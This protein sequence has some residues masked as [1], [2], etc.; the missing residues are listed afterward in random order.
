MA[1]EVNPRRSGSAEATAALSRQ[2]RYQQVVE[3]LRLKEV[4]ISEHERFVVCSNPAA[5][6][7]DAATRDRLVARLEA[8]ISDSDRLSPTKRA[9]LRGVISI[10]QVP[11]AHLLCWLAPLLARIVETRA[12]TTWTRARTQLQRLH[13]GT[14]TGSAGIF[15]QTT[16][17]DTETRR[18]HQ[19]PRR[20]APTPDPAP[21]HRDV[22][23]ALTRH[24]THA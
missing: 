18:L 14:F 6:D 23:T 17:P 21:G 22:H 19:A 20:D 7:R 1:A 2:G 5:A 12:D 16:P 10:K 11:A 15:R 9:E 8:M 13:V 3:N 24:N 4:K